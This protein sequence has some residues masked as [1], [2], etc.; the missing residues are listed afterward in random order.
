MLRPT[1]G[2]RLPAAELEKIGWQNYESL[3]ELTV[4]DARY[5]LTL[6]AGG[7]RRALSAWFGELG[8]KIGR[9]EWERL[10][11]TYERAY[12]ETLSHGE[13]LEFH[14]PLRRLERSYPAAEKSVAPHS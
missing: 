3:G 4:R 11:L 8:A 13:T 1:R 10:R 6:C 5:L 14:V 9:R 12:A 2:Y 7:Q